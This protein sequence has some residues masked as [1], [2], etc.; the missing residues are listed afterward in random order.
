MSKNWILFVCFLIVGSFAA[1]N[2]EEKASIARQYSA[3]SFEEIKKSYLTMTDIQFEAYIESLKGKTVEWEG[4]VRDINEGMIGGYSISVY[5]NS[6]ND[7]VSLEIPSNHPHISK[8]NSIQKGSIIKFQGEI[9]HTFTLLGLRVF[10][11]L[12]YLF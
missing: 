3:V 2:F 11:E 12:Y 6:N 9:S 4:R 1:C 7:I 5:M 8:L 10:L